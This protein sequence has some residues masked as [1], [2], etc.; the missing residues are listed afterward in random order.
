MSLGVFSCSLLFTFIILQ[1]T[2]ATDT[3]LEI[4]SE[5]ADAL[6]DIKKYTG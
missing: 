5:L 1:I 4:D 6:E 3:M 2:K